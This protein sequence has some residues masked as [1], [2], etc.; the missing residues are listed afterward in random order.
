[1]VGWTRFD[2]RKPEGTMSEEWRP[3]RGQ[4]IKAL[5]AWVATEPDG[6]EGVASVQL[7]GVHMPM[8]GADMDRIKSLRPHAELVRR[9][10]GYPVRLIRFAMREDLEELP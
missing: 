8:V 5:Y 10:T 9:A 6:G 7:G 2:Q 3:G 1:M 4:K